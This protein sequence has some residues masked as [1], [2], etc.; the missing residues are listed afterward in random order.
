MTHFRR[1]TA[2]KLPESVLFDGGAIM[3]S[4]RRVVSGSGRRSAGGVGAGIGAGYIGSFF[5]APPGPDDQLDDALPP[6]CNL[7]SS[8]DLSK[9]YGAS[10]PEDPPSSSFLSKRYGES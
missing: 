3:S 8:S 4:G 2:P 6:L 7:P 5:R 9:Q 10:N 1:G